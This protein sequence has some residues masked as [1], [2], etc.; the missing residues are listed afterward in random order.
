MGYL[1]LKVKL[2]RH[3]SKFNIL[4]SN[5]ILILLGNRECTILPMFFLIN[6]LKQFSLPSIKTFFCTKSF[7]HF[8]LVIS[9]STFQRKER[10]IASLNAGNKY[11]Q[12]YENLIQ[13]ILMNVQL[14]SYI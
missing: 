3:G 10:K 9:L 8:S 12:R 2:S 7:L 4:S 11:E 5:V 1:N 13:L 6:S 14:L